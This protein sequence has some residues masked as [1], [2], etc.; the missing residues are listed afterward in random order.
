[1]RRYMTVAVLLAAVAG[2]STGREYEIRGQVLAVNRE[3]AEL[4]ITHDD[5]RGFMPAMTMPFKVRDEKWLEGRQPGDLVTATLVVEDSGAYLARVE[6]TGHA[7]LTA[8]PP[9]SFPRALEA[10]DAVP[11]VAVVD[12][13]GV[14]RRL[15]EW[16]GRITAITFIYTRCPLPGFCPLMD[17]HFAAIQRAVM[18]DDALR[19]RVR[20]VSV[21]FD[22]RR[23]TPAVLAEHAQRVGADPEVWSF[24]TGEL[25]AIDA[26][27]QQFGVSIIREPAGAEIV[28]NL[29][30]VVVDPVGRV[31]KVFS[32][33]EWTPAQALDEVR[34][35]GV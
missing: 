35:A 20:L 19:D 31:V 2:C 17:R 13:A 10:G 3:R 12:Q 15:S 21:S 5:I 23:D 22:P 9:V 32:G 18:S 27:A 29:R 7:P 28:H 11:D 14:A 16:R 1:M 25:E 26:F 30:T 4:T 6:R 8:P 34:R 33:N 24:V